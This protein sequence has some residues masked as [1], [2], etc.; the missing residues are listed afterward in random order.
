ML[1]PTTPE[2]TRSIVKILVPR[3]Y[4]GALPEIDDAEIVIIDQSVPV[5]DEH[6]DAEVLVAW[7]Q[8]NDVLRDS[9]ERL[10]NLKLIQAFLAG[11][12]SIV[13]AGFP[14]EVP[15]ATG[16]GLHDGP[17]AEHA[18]AMT[19]SLLRL[20]PLAVQNAATHTWDVKHAGAMK[21]RADD[22]RVTTL[23]GA[24]VTIWGYG[25]IGST[26]AP[27]VKMLGAE[28]TG[29]AR[30]AGDR[31][32]V[33]VVTEDGLNEVLAL[34]DVLV[35]I[36]PNHASTA[37]AMNAERFAALKPGALLVNVGRGSTVDEAALVAAL[38]SGRLAAAAIDVTA[39][40]PLPA[41]SPLWDQPNLLITP[42]IAG[43]RP[44]RG[45]VLLAHN[46]AA[47]RNGTEVRNLVRR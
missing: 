28:V 12:D 4:R 24:R 7:G 33:P 34:T 35:M 32:G 30:T 21:V 13:A 25:S 16:V 6:L 27:L 26:F 3:A 37:L 19:L 20:L 8:P 31:G 9:A 41:D 22:G 47:V 10:T 29:V 39:T 2:H 40:E 15:I 23:D 11:P 46:V 36:L 43:G 14:P 1:E 5:P 42:H 18:L 44:Q 17:V 45:D 38:G